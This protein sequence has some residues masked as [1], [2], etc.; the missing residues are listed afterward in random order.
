MFGTSRV[1]EEL[2]VIGTIDPDAYGTG[3][4]NGDVIDMAKWRRVLFILLAG[5]LGSSATLDFEV[6]GDVASNGSF[7]TAITGKEITQLTQAGTDSDKQVLVEVTSEEVAAQGLRYIRPTA[8]LGTAT[9]D[10]AMIALGVPAHST[11]DITGSDL[12][13]VDEVIS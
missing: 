11:R 4:Q 8:T 9:S 13:S 6:F 12:A 3:A 2:A 1:S 5:E 10:Y 7:A